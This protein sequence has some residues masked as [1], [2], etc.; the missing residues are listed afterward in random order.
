MATAKRLVFGDVNVDMI[1]GPSEIGV[2][3]DESADIHN[4]AVD[5]LSQAEHDEIASA[6]MVCVSEEFAK[7]VKNEIYEILPTLKRENIA[8]K[9]IENKAAFVVAKDLNEAVDLMNELAVEHLEIAT[10]NA[11]ELLPKIKHAGAIF[12][13]HFT[14]E[15]M[16]DYLAGPNHTLPTG[17]SARFFSPLGVYNFIK[18]SSIISLNK[19]A[20]DE[21]GEACMALADAEGLGAHKLS[22]KIRYKK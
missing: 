15:A 14:P 1:A 20:I 3:T 8:R 6:L 22:V 13:G 7:A 19:T 21:L 10:D 16:G 5:L 9:S 17:G 18:R 2:I 11:Y 4:T 12:L